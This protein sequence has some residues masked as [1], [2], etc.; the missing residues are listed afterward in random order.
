MMQP[1]ELLLK[2]HYK[3]KKLSVPI[4]SIDG[5]CLRALV[6]PNILRFEK[7]ILSKVSTT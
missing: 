1:P 7:E 3:G 2:L 5:R 6:D 4:T